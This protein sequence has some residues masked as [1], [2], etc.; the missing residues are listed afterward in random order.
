MWEKLNRVWNSLGIVPRTLWTWLNTVWDTTKTALYSVLNPVEW[1]WK[2]ATS[3]KNAIH[4]ACNS[5]KKSWYKVPLSLLASPFM[6]VEWVTETLWYSWS[7]LLSNI[8]DTIA[9]PFINLWNS[10]KW[11]WS[12]NGFSGFKFNKIDS[13]DVSPKNRLANQ[14][15]AATPAP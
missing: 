1:L 6:A 12:K 2:T 13:E 14:F 10:I 11:M 4:N 5:G 15:K 9:N 3:I 8:R 7:H